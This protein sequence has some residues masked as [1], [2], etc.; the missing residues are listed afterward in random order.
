M[1]YIACAFILFCLAVPAYAIDTEDTDY[2]A[3]MEDLPLMPGLK[4]IP[5]AT[6]DF[7][8]PEGRIMEAT[9]NGIVDPGKVAQFYAQTLPQLGWKPISAE[10]YVRETEMLHIETQPNG[11]GATVHFTVAPYAAAAK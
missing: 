10:R 1:K 3:G 4:I 6:T 5:S 9:A 11:A 8:Q 2:I 7:D